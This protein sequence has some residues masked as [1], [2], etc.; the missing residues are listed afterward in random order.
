MNEELKIIIKAITEDA[1][2]ELEEV[3][4]ELQ[5]INQEGEK[6]SKGLS[7]SFSKITKT[8]AIVAGAITAVV[9]TMVAL[10]KSSMEFQK[11]NSK[12]IT[13]FQAVGSSAEQANTT[14]KELYSFLGD[15]DTATEA[16][17]SLALITTNTKD[18]AE[19]TN[20]L[21]GAY[22]LMGDKL[23]TEGLAESINE[24]IRN[25][26]TVTGSLADA[27]VWLGVQE[28]AVNNKLASLNSQ[29]EREAY[30][31]E[32]LNGLYSNSAALY[33][34]NNAATIAYNQSQ[35]NLDIALAN[36]TQYVV[37]LLTQLNNLGAVLL[38]VLAPAFRYVSAFIA[39]F[40]E[41]VSAAIGFIGAFFG[42]FAEEGSAA[43]QTVSQGLAG[44]KTD[45]AGITDGVGGLSGAFDDAAESAKEL[46]KQ[47]MGFD[48]LNVVSSNKTASSAPVGGAGGIGAGAG[49]GISIPDMGG[50]TGL[51][52]FKNDVEEVREKVEAVMV[53]VGLTA[54]AIALWKLTSFINDLKNSTELLNAFKT[55][56]TNI[57]GWMMIVAGA[58][59]LIKGYSDAWVN[60]IDWGNFALILGG[61][62]LIVGGL[63]VAISPLTGAIG[64]IVGGIAMLILGI[65]D[66]VENGYS[67]EAVIM[68]AVG[69]ITILVGVI[70]AF[71][72]ALLAN[73]ITWIVV[74]IMALVAAFVIL[75]NECEGFRNFWINLWEAIKVAFNA[76]VEWLKKACADIGT[77]F[78]NAWESIKKAW[79]ATG[80]WF[81][82]IWQSIKNAFSAVGSWFSDIFTGAWNGIKKAF[83]AVGS[84]FSGIWE[85]I[86]NIFSKVGSTIAS[87]VSNAFSSAI[88]WVL[89]KAIGIINGFIS[90]I[91]LAIS[92]IN[93][94]PG[95]NIGTLKKLDVPKLAKGGIV[96]SATLAVVGERGKEAV[97][98]LENNTGWMD[99]LADKIAS[100]NAA[101]TKLVL[102]L[103]SREL[104]WANI[105]SINSIT[106]QTG[107][108]QLTL[109]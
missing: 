50:L 11:A 9:G 26:G 75:W 39:V 49:G 35:A 73:P 5:K 64:L 90:A 69:A 100:K 25:G 95:V 65:K 2:K 44:V 56:L 76:V 3:K 97:L 87:A 31:R 94:I 45:V 74:A 92:I 1:Q 28:D 101:P 33:E 20:I 77:F 68:V 32:L 53:L 15:V 79:S 51:E 40:V 24:T 52:N 42:I 10:T 108:L 7:E 21:Q 59:L 17:Q 41:Y 103:D 62:G 4:K 38:E 46:K 23:P 81:K 30:L 109:V 57:G 98:P 70:W 82:N 88:N 14:Y 43:T 102:M 47:T 71:N 67:M 18:L 91:N 12:L 13:S 80:Q 8:A 19:W 34:R 84:F 22:S 72:A 85:S 104:G 55:K 86:K 78:V 96:D 66:L 105:Q 6:S 61:I 99:S 58:I 36:A 106:K 63:V 89:E 37:P 27:L 48:E 83:S 60:G 29:A 54:A 16:A 107:K 93:A